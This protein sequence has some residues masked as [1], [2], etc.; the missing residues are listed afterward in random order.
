M[1][2]IVS[3]QMGAEPIINLG[4]PPIM[5]D[6]G[7]EW[8][9][10]GMDISWIFIKYYMTL[11]VCMRYDMFDICCETTGSGFWSRPNPAD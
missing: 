11:Y 4:K 10:I 1:S 2:S 3:L 7:G 9:F 6:I 8:E 5:G